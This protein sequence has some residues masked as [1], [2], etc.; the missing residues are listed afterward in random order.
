MEGYNCFESFERSEMSYAESLFKLP[1]GCAEEV[2]SNLRE[3][4]RLRLQDTTLSKKQ[5]FDVQQNARVINNAEKYY[6]TM[7]SGG[8]D[9]WN[10]RDHH[11]LE[12]LEQLLQHHQQNGKADS[13]AI[14]WAHNTHIG[15]YHATDMAD[16]GYLNLGGLAREKFG[17]ENVYLVGFG[18]HHGK[19]TAG[20]AWKTP[21]ETMVLP[22]AQA[23]TYEDYFHKATVNLEA[24]QILTTFN[25][26]EKSSPLYHK[27]GHRAVGVVYDPEY[28]KH[29]HNYVPT[30]LANR[31]DSFIFVDET[32]ALRPLGTT[33]SKN[34]FPETYPL[35]F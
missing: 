31:Y 6:R 26:L 27:L 34:Q 24:K 1:N 2:I 10:I 25:H 11:M 33:E 22:V 20:K 14:V 28:E 19:V 3:L 18:T 9:S 16:A 12:T 29:G 5:L 21:Q 32:N 7:L 23:G 13:K 4:L 35:G 15:D 8:A 17:V 30:E